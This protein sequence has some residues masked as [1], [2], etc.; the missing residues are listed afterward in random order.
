MSHQSMPEIRSVAVLSRDRRVAS[1]TSPGYRHQPMTKH[2][3]AADKLL[4]LQ[5][6]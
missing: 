2:R 6:L 5:K 3:V 4:K 1:A